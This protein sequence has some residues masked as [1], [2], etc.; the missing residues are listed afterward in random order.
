[1]A[2]LRK[3]ARDLLPPVIVR[4]VMKHRKRPGIVFEGGFST[5]ESAVDR[6]RGYDA[7][8]VSDAVLE[9]TLKVQSGEAEFE[10][11]SVLFDH[12]EYSWPMTAGLMLGAAIGGGRLRVLDFGGALGSHYFQNRKFLNSLGE[13]V[14]GV[15][16]QANYVERG[17]RYIEDDNLRFYS[18]IEEC[19]QGLEPNVVVAS[20]VIQY[21]ENPL[22]IL[23]ALSRVGAKVILLDRTPYTHD[24]RDA[25][26]KVQHVPESIYA[27]S[28]PCWFLNEAEVVSVPGSEGY[29]LVESFDALDKLDATATWKG[30]IFTG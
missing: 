21:L 7:A 12:I 27:A 13:S 3:I 26:V 11:D 10:R 20:S 25:E 17:K 23:A 5:W 1:M 2:N 24:R 18:S 22:E 16:E 8:E 14:W 29:S 6:S 28:Y 9:A 19:A 15:V 4:Q 30:H